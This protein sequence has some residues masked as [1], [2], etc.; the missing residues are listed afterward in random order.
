[1]F[2]YFNLLNTFLD[3][4]LKKNM[5]Y[6]V[7]SLL[8][9]SSAV[10]AQMGGWSAADPKSSEVV[11]AA[12][13]AVHDRFLDI[14]AKFK[15]II[16][17]KQV[18]IINCEVWFMYFDLFF[19]GLLFFLPPLRHFNIH[20]FTCSHVHKVVAGINYDLVVESTPDG[21]SCEVDHFVVWDR[22][23]AMSVTKNV[24]LPRPCGE[25]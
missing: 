21:S 5:L 1:M 23:G 2:C 7:L 10:C 8:I 3:A 4:A 18:C 13:F 19:V 20:M 17:K 24:K 6:F 12:K 15:V 16:A 11:A 9:I 22:F 25:E 14:P